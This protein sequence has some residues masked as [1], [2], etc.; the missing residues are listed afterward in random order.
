MS[1][2]YVMSISNAFSY[3]VRLPAGSSV[4]KLNMSLQSAQIQPD[5]LGREIASRLTTAAG[6]PDLPWFSKSLSFVMCD[7]TSECNQILFLTLHNNTSA[8]TGTPDSGGR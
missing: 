3:W 4:S 6:Q 5:V 7:D 2:H 1:Y 8:G